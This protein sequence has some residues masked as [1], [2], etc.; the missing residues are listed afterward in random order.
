MAIKFIPISLAISATT[1]PVDFIISKNFPNPFNPTTTIQYFLPMRTEV[2]TVIYDALGRKI[3]QLENKL[4]DFGVHKIVWNG[5]NNLGQEMPSGVYLYKVI[6]KDH[7][8]SGKMV[9]VR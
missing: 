2:E 5:L 3:A 9:L 1:K 8:Q 4:K 6:S 7:I